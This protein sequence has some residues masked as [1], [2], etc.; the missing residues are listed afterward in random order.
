MS[1]QQYL[2]QNP[3]RVAALRAA[4]QE[5]PPRWFNGIEYLE[6]VHGAPRLVLYFVHDLAKATPAPLPCWQGLSWTK[7]TR[8]PARSTWTPPSKK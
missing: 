1:T 2:C 3:R 4:A 8:W 5:T 7:T 6:V